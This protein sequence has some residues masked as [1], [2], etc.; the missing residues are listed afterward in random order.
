MIGA[1]KVAIRGGLETLYFTGSHVALSPLVRGIGVILTMHHVRPA[2]SGKFQPNRLLEL[3]PS[4]L[5]EVITHLRRN[6]YDFVSLDEMRRRLVAG[7]NGRRFVCMTFDDGY[8]DN[9]TYAHP[10]LKRYDVPF[11]IYVPTSYPDGAGELWWLALEAV[12][13]GNDRL[14]L[15]MDGVER[16]FSCTTPAEKFGAY[17]TIYWR[18]RELPT[19]EAMRSTIDALC[20]R[21]DVDLAAFCGELCMTWEEIAQLAAD[22][23]VTIAAHTVNHPMLRKLPDDEVRW[24]MQS[25]VDAIAAALGERP[26]HLSYPIGDVS[27]AGPREFRIAQELGFASAVTTRPGVLFR[28]HRDHL[29]ALPR[30]SLN[31]EFQRKRYVSVLLSGTATAINNRF[32]RVNAA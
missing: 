24:E 25:S 6:K 10:I 14:T 5:E 16:Y 15:T 22:P 8:R 21:Y 19:V 7:A 17:E 13:A 32:R 3:T 18:L 9:L 12:I 27:S 2:R 26:R 30:I 23:L 31:G 4:F 20:A 1:R 28:Q 29:T 11:A